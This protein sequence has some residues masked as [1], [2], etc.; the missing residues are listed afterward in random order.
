MPRT[1]G[2]ES[3]LCAAGGWIRRKTQSTWTAISASSSMA[4]GRSQ[5]RTGSHRR[6]GNVWFSEGGRAIPA[7]LWPRTQA[8]YRTGRAQARREM[9][10][11]IGANL[12]N[13]EKRAH[14]IDLKREHLIDQVCT[15]EILPPEK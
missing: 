14:L 5:P 2:S 3:N 11:G 7:P 10:K 1:S 13:D 6:P 15:Q 8:R 12:T 4:M 9:T